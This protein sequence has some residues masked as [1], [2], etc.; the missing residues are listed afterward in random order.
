MKKY[1]I[2]LVFLF[3]FVLISISLINL[4]FINVIDVQAN[5]END[6]NYTFEKDV[7]YKSDSPIIDSSFNM[8]PDT[9]ITKNYPGTYSFT[10]ES[11]LENLDISF[12]DEINN[13]TE[14]GTSVKYAQANHD[15]VLEIYDDT[16][17]YGLTVRNNFGPPKT[18]GTIEWWYLKTDDSIID[19]FYAY[20]DN[21]AC[22]TLQ[23]TGEGQFAWYDGSVHNV[24]AYSEN[25]WYHHRITFSASKFD[26]FINGVLE[27]DDSTFRNAQSSM[28][29]V[30]MIT[31][32][33]GNHYKIYY[34][35]I[36]YS[37]DD[38]YNVNDNSS[39]LITINETIQEVDKYQFKYEG[40]NDL[41]DNGDDNPSSWFDVE[42]GGDDVN[43]KQIGSGVV[44]ILTDGA[45]DY[46]GLQK[47]NIGIDN[48][49]RLNISYGFKIQEFY[50]VLKNGMYLRVYSYDNTKVVEVRVRNNNGVGEMAYWV[51]GTTYVL[52]NTEMLINK[53]YDVNLYIDY[54]NDVCKLIY[55]TDGVLTAS[56]LF[57]LATVSKIG[58][59]KVSFITYADTDSCNVQVDFIGIYINGESITQEFAYQTVEISESIHWVFNHQN[60]LNYNVKGNLSIYL[61]AQNYGG[62]FIQISTLKVVDSSDTI[63]VYSLMIGGFNYG[64]APLTLYIYFYGQIEGLKIDIN[65]VKLIEGENMYYPTYDYEGIDQH[66]NYFYV[67][68]DTN[69]LHF[70]QTSNDNNLEYIQAT[71][72]IQNIQTV[73]RS[74]SYTSLL[75]GNANGHL[76]VS[77]TDDMSTLIPLRTYISNP[78]I[79]LPQD[80]M[81]ETL[82][83]LI[84]DD[85]NDNI[86]GTTIG[87]IS[88]ITLKYMPDIE[89]IILTYALVDVV[90]PLMI[91]II[92][93]FL[94]YVKL[95][96]KSILPMFLLMNLICFITNLI[97][98]WLFFIIT[99][100]CSGF[101][102]IQARGD[103]E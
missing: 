54:Y 87:Y 29:N 98:I 89:T 21:T 6:V 101:I 70:I 8:K 33:A 31:N 67:N 74:I 100:A 13:G 99:F 10:Y 42:D 93:A 92:P 19:S 56:Y 45:Q 26:W 90:I 77:Y 38:N 95:G 103:S 86:Q 102:I 47:E 44:E 69:S 41:F 17:L 75:T 66:N 91:M 51:T 22:M 23:A 94:V 37:W 81:I 85:D 63:N 62:S 5:S 60:L 4:N 12:V 73:N 48:A 2:I 59:N 15:K 49:E 43:C 3:I 46:L 35:G 97:P 57:P 14:H 24:R 83:I 78:N 79:V 88:D 65:G 11:G 50:S 84:T 53:A 20:N 64:I 39:P 16:A 71:F 72:N 36:G 27:A 30:R 34:D 40:F 82:K 80:K 61:F 96:K 76:R 18:S 28:N 55:K 1:K 58:L 68:N 25:I 9:H 52:L 32:V 7:F